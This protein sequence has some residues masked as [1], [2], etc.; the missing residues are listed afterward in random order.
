MTATGHYATV[1]TDSDGHK[2]LGTA[3]DPVKDQTDFLAR[4]SYEQLDHLMFPIGDLPKEEVRRI[5]A[6]VHMPNAMRKDSQGICFL[7][8]INYNDFIR[9]HLGER[10]GPIVEIETGRKLGEHRGFWFHTI[11]QRKGLGLSGGPWY[12]VRKNAHDNVVYVSGGYDTAKQYGDTLPLTEMHYISGC[13]WTPE[14][15]AKGVDITFKNRHTPEFTD[16][17]MTLAPNGDYVVRAAHQVQGIAP[18]Q[19]CVIYDKERHRCFGS[20]IITGA[21]VITDN[22]D[23]K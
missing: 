7:G 14:D 20:G 3:I 23:T 11:G 12:V 10:P 2:W 1:I 8:K 18:G 6:E 4:I 19:F 22:I 15:L 21:S 17:T 16:A 5:A 13:P 9:R